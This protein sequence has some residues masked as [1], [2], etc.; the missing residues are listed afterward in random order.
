M[1]GQSACL[2]PRSTLSPTDGG[3]QPGPV[4]KSL[5]KQ[6]RVLERLVSSECE[7][8]R[9]SACFGCAITPA[10]VGTCPLFPVA[11]RPRSPGSGGTRAFQSIPFGAVVWVSILGTGAGLC[12]SGAHT[13]IWETDMGGGLHT[14]TPQDRS[15]GCGHLLGARAMSRGEE[16][17]SHLLAVFRDR[18]IVGSPAPRTQ[19]PIREAS[20]DPGD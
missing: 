18:L 9:Q 4:P 15:A 19:P 3:T 12:P 8:G 11:S 1:R 20:E 17:G 16:A 10:T 5:Q 13:A 6:R 2:D 14:K 7:Y